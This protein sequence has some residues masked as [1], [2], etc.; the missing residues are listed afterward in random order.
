MVGYVFYTGWFWLGVLIIALVL[1][2]GFLLLEQYHK[3][4]KPH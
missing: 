4:R 3:R 1:S 2:I